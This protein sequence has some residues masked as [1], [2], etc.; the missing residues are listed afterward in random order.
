M[1]PKAEGLEHVVEVEGELHTAADGR[2]EV[3]TGVQ[4]R[5]DQHE[6][7]D[8]FGECVGEVVVDGRDGTEN[9]ELNLL[10]GGC[11]PMGQVVEIDQAGAAHCA[12]N[13]SDDVPGDLIPGEFTEGCQ[14]DGHGGVQV[15][16]GVGVGG[17]DAE[18]DGEAPAEGDGEEVVAVA[19]GPAKFDV[20]DDAA[21][22]G[23]HDER[24][25]EL[26]KVGADGVHGMSFRS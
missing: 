6:R 1:K 22:D 13:L 3:H 17:V 7:T 21:A 20:G 15:A 25:E 2:L 16:A 5:E 8:H 24:A 26:G 10:V 23:A 14:A 11:L 12:E 4:C 19:F 18:G 9:A